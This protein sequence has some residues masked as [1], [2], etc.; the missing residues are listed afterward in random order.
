MVRQGRMKK[1]SVLTR[2]QLESVPS[3]KRMIA[4]YE[5]KI[6]ELEADMPGGIRAMELKQNPT[7]STSGY[8]M[9]DAVVEYIQDVESYEKM[10]IKAK[11]KLVIMLRRINAFVETIDDPRAKEIVGLHC[12]EGVSFTEIAKK[13]H[14]SVGQ[15]HK[16]YTKTLKKYK[17]S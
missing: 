3:I 6:Q 14:Y 7:P 10:L 5:Q 16:I 9:E 17:I 1:T 2:R 4:R 15:T 12:E 11:A 8:G 13:V